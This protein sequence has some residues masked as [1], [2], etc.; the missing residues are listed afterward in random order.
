MVS[1][2][3]FI[4]GSSRIP[5]IIRKSGFLMTCSIFNVSDLTRVLLATIRNLGRCPCPR[6]EIQKVHVGGLGTN[7]DRQRRDHERTDTPSRIA[8]IDAARKA[9]FEKGAGVSSTRVE[10]ILKERSEVP[11]HVSEII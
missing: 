3:D 10:N 1:H 4:H 7:V 11:T 6:C 2:D 5:R 8:R 9:I